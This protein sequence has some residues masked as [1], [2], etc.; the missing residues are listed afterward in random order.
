MKFTFRTSAAAAMLL[1]S[2]GAMLVA[3]PAAAQSRYGY[4]QHQA[5]AQPAIERFVLRH[6]DAL[7][8]GLE[9]RFRLVGAPGGQ[10]WFAIPGMQRALAMQETRPGIYEADYLIRRRDNPDALARAVGTLQT[11]GQ[12]FTALVQ[13]RAIDGG[14]GY[15]RDARPPQITA[16]TPSQG[17]RGWTRLS[18]RVMDQ[19]SGVDPASLVMRVDGRD[20][21]GRVRIDGDEVRYAEN[22]QPGRH[23]AELVVRDR[24]GNA[25]RH[26]WAFDVAT[27]GRDYGSYGFYGGYR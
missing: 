20:V 21:T 16:Q 19:G 1:A 6:A 4:V 15:Q 27:I 23:Q 5:V 3:Q 8:P 25:A 26:V 12:R 13:L 10:A 2:T 7:E 22:L 24:A 18:A 14:P 9:V 11:G 17:Q